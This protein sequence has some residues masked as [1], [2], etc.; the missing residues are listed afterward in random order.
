MFTVYY[1]TMCFHSI[2]HL[3]VSLHMTSSCK[4]TRIIKEEEK[5]C[6][7]KLNFNF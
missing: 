3:K 6:I 4:N 7:F 5:D 1:P 2:F